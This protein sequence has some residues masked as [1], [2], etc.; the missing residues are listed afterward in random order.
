[1]SDESS[2]GR[3]KQ[4]ATD[5]R[6]WVPF[7][8]IGVI[9]L[10]ISISLV[11]SLDTRE[12]PEPDID[13]DLAFERAEADVTAEIREAVK[14]ATHQ[15]GEAPVTTANTSNAVGQAL[16][17]AND[18]DDVFKNYVRLLIYLRA[19]E[20]LE[21]SE[22]SV[23][24]A[25]ASA[26]L[27]ALDESN[28]E[29]RLESVNLKI[30]RESPQL[31]Y[32]TVRVTIEDV[33]FQVEED[34]QVI[35]TREE[36]VTVSVGTTLFELHDRTT[37]YERQLD[38]GFFEGFSE[39]GL[40][41]GFGQQFALRLYPIAYAKS[42]LKYKKPDT[43]GF[44]EIAPNDQ[45][46][47]LA[48][49][50]KYSLQR[51]AFGTTDPASSEEMS[52][53]VLCFA[54]SEASDKLFEKIGKNTE[55]WT[56]NNVDDEVN[57]VLK[58]QLEDDELA[59]ELAAKTGEVVGENIGE[60]VEG[61]LKKA[62][63][64]EIMCKVIRKAVVEDEDFDVDISMWDLI[65][66]FEQDDDLTSPEVEARLDAAAAIAYVEIAETKNDGDLPKKVRK[67]VPTLE[68]ETNDSMKPSFE[69]PSDGFYNEFD[70]DTDSDNIGEVIDDIYNIRVSG[71]MEESAVI[72]N[73][74]IE[75]F[76]DD[77]VDKSET[78]KEV[79]TDVD[80][81]ANEIMA[82]ESERKS[83]EQTDQGFY[84]IEIK[85]DQTR[86]IEREWTEC[87]MRNETTGECEETETGGDQDTYSRIGEAN[88]VINGTYSPDAER[89]DDLLLENAYVSSSGP[90]KTPNN[91][92]GI[93]EDAVNNRI[94][95][96]S[97][98]NSPDDIEDDIRNAVEEPDN[99]GNQINFNEGET[100]ISAIN[101]SK[102]DAMEDWL[103]D[104]LHTMV[105][106]PSVNESRI[107]QEGDYKSPSLL[108]N[109]SQPRVEPIDVNTTKYLSNPDGYEPFADLRV[110]LENTK[111]EIV[112]QDVED[113]EYKNAADLARAE[114]YHRFVN[115]TESR[116]SD[117]G[118]EQHKQIDEMKN[119]DNSLLGGFTETIQDE[120]T[121]NLLGEAMSFKDTVFGNDQEE[122]ATPTEELNGSPLLD[123]VS[124]EIHGSPT[125]LSMDVADRSTTPAV[126]PADVGRLQ[127]TED[128]LADD[129][130]NSFKL[131]K[132]PDENHSSMYGATTNVPPYPGI[133]LIP[134]KWLITLGMWN[135]E[136]GGEYAR[137]EVSAT[138]GD[139]MTST[140]YV[141]EERPVTLDIDGTDH[142]VGRVEPI[143]FTSRTILGVI[144]PGKH[145]GVGD[146][147]IEDWTS[148]ND[149][150]SNFAACSETYPQLGPGYEN[151][152]LLE[153]NELVDNV[154]KEM[155]NINAVIPGIDPLPGEET[156][157]ALDCTTL[158]LGNFFGVNI[159][160]HLSK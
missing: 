80:V 54:A 72:K 25:T 130:E 137:F 147:S 109:D 159:E 132:I 63:V 82:T 12:D 155:N 86:E 58:E 149:L 27:P 56:K 127:D 120:V 146:G 48:N 35:G 10:I 66:S 26:S 90:G 93:P 102:K 32:G 83:P 21:A 156:V 14:D 131:A 7:A 43:F 139:P 119:G 129:V 99:I 100:D 124:F 17:N 148:P 50:A 101:E 71:D 128:L 19:S 123:E 51:E 133:P 85:V 79:N 61:E 140:T 46:E 38:M 138:A 28:A 34:G 31:D 68:V 30:G 64:D 126:R 47:L 62:D 40:I 118:E 134:P 11:A 154:T 13:Q 6:G 98:A 113:N 111:E 157:K 52:A 75:S 117:V 142:E 60:E 44:E 152:E 65:G 18:E 76:P 4:L 103:Q 16:A 8:M 69:D 145:P 67:R 153:G 107:N 36:S 122:L 20:R 115:R 112:F 151:Q 92:K 5:N 158:Q 23:R 105:F 97:D 150:A 49:H 2:D 73:K 143:N 53:A 41:S 125:Y 37:E 121:D 29:E 94:G 106:G 136:M 144:M 160:K 141:R 135:V 42:G 110:N 84:V 77:T 78:D 22:Q 3:L 39:D 88:L 33:K 114:L 104:E 59:K 70:F 57:G 24:G 9:L 91:F 74:N 116:I 95:E 108:S 81:D 45:N 1:M 89:A 87:T 15:A 55:D 96:V